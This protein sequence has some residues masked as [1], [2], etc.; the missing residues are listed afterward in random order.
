[1]K[2]CRLVYSSVMLWK[3][4]GQERYGGSF[5]SETKPR[6][7]MKEGLDEMVGPNLSN[8]YLQ[9]SDR[10][11]FNFMRFACVLIAKVNQRPSSKSLRE[12][13]SSPTP[14]RFRQSTVQSNRSFCLYFL[15][16]VALK[17]LF[18]AEKT[19]SK[20][21]RAKRQINSVFFF[22]RLFAL[23]ASRKL[24]GIPQRSLSIVGAAQSRCIVVFP[25]RPGVRD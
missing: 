6:L 3:D 13:F 11:A 19:A 23:N 4:C 1:M 2:L 21:L 9:R 14:R 8:N 15:G 12:G 22:F 16:K 18:L 24:R 7:I 17:R 20:P 5:V 25:A 10:K